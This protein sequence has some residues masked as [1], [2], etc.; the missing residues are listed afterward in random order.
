MKQYWKQKLRKGDRVCR[1]DE[2]IKKKK[3][4]E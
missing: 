1:M 2:D 4:D 3:I